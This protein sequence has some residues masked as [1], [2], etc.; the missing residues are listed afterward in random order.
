[1]S[2][3]LSRRAVVVA[4]LFSLIT[5][6]IVYSS[7]NITQHSPNLKKWGMRNGYLPVAGNKSINS[8]CQTCAVVTSSSHLLGTRLGS[9]IDH[10]ACTIR[11]N[12]APTS[13]YEVDIGSKTTFR[14]VAHS[15][16]YRVLRRPQ[17]FLTK[18]TNTTV[19]FWGPP[20]KMQRNHKGNL[21]GLIQRASSTFPNISAFIISPSKMKS[22]DVLFRRETGKDSSR[23]A[24]HK[25]AYHYY[26]P[27]GP[28]ECTTYIQN[29]RSR[30]GN[31]HRFITEKLV[32]ARWATLYN[33]TFSHP[34]W[35]QEQ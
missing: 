20:E 5:L 23:H 34:Q 26:E 35:F 7:S 13:G 2:S 25:R 15:S 10:S 18:T 21:L 17:E 33:I 9:E 6:L 28:D 8:Q 1:M 31:H 12:D 22:F 16:V 11:M 29:E 19:I 30:R 32:F 14:V 3:G 4:S 27:K 24:P